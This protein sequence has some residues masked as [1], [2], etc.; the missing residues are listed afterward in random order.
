MYFRSS[1]RH[2]PATDQTDSYYRLVESY[3]NETDRVCHRTLLNVGFLNELINIDE[4]NQVRRII[5]KRYQDIKG[6][7]ELFDI[8]DKIY[9]YDLTNTYFEGRKKGSRYNSGFMNFHGIILIILFLVRI[10]S[11]TAMQSNMHNWLW[12]K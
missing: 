2:N 6:G 3:R 8:E 12:R 4:L 7:N 9:L 11:K 1:I 10:F 5:H